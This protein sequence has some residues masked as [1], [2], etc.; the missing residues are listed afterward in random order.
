MTGMKQRPG[1]LQPV[2]QILAASA[3]LLLPLFLL[4]AVRELWIGFTQ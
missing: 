2:R 1:I 4:E 3:I